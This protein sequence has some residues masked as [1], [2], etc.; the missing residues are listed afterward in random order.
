MRLVV[1]EYLDNQLDRTLR[2]REI[3]AV[4][5]ALDEA[6][7]ASVE[8][9]V[10][11]SE[12][13]HRK[14]E[15][16]LREADHRKNEFLATLAHEL[17]NPLAPLRNSLELVRLREDSPSAIRHAR[18]LMNR[19]VEQM[20]RLVEDLLDVTR[21][22]QGKLVL[23][24]E[25]IDL[26]P[27]ITQAVQMNAPLREARRHRLSVSL[28][29][30]PLW[31]EADP[32]RLVQV[33]VNLLNNAA[34]YTPD[35]GEI[36]IS[37]TREGNEAV[38][39]VKDNGVGIPPEKLNQIF[40]MFTQLD[41]DAEHAQSGLGIGLT[42][43]RRLVE[44]HGGSVSVTSLGVGKGS[45]FVVRLPSTTAGSPTVAAPSPTG[46]I[47]AGSRHVLIIE[48]NHDG[49][50]S[51]AMLLD[52]LGHRVS[53]AEDGLKGLD[54]I[55]NLRPEIALIDIGLPGMDGYELARRARAVLGGSVVLIALTGYGSPEDRQQATEAGFNSFLLKPVD[56]AALQQLLAEPVPSAS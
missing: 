3:Q 22:A 55:L 42:L 9:Y 28:S 39:R 26:D 11:S 29:P 27:A 38:V 36:A 31:V 30:T 32:V 45:E 43:V 56:L 49:R 6:I 16:S 12:D 17:R 37:A 1:L 19:Q 41:S 5:L 53:V 7:E 51:L 44:L 15:D 46:A 33:L 34:K 10:R 24:K 8:R 20:T 54:A 40:E 14:L 48:D 52:L 2:L 4:G 35:G 18:E 23:K 50:D 47:P 13:Q 21:I 25:H